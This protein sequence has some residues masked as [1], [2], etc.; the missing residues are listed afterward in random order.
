MENS[1]LLKI[2]RE[3]ERSVAWLGR[4][5]GVSRSYMRAM[6]HGKRN[7]SELYKKKC[8]QILNKDYKELFNA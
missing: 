5:C 4:Q 3:Q 1:G 6:I 7:F 8:S 2:L